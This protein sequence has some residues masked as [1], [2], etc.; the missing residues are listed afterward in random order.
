MA[1]STALAGFVCMTFGGLLAACSSGSSDLAGAGIADKTSS[2]VEAA[3]KQPASAFP[4][5]GRW[6]GTDGNG[7]GVL[8][9]V[10]EAEWAMFS[11]VDDG[12]VGGPAAMTVDPDSNGVLSVRYGFFPF[13]PLS[14][15]QHTGYAICEINGILL[16]QDTLQG[17][18]YC[19]AL[20]DDP[21]LTTI[22]LTRDSGARTAADIRR[23][24]GAWTNSDDSGNDVISIGLDGNFTGQ[25]GTN[26]CFY[27]GSI[28]PADSSYEFYEV[29][30]LF[31][32][33]VAELK[34][35]NDVVFTGLVSIDPQADPA[36]FDLL[37]VGYTGL[38]DINVNGIATGLMRKYSR[39]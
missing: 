3:L 34:E 22:N 2:V 32:A 8:L 26:G 5:H 33:C 9:L 12:I 27:R 16:E 20:Y 37:T 13:Y 29:E 15:R 30:W 25:H 23:L 1:R 28:S 4:A 24:S 18:L 31:E 19:T 14:H 6:V 10:S 17:S 7:R 39:W 38:D 11:F 21:Y 35:L 36:A